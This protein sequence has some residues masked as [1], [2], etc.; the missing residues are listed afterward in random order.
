MKD[1]MAMKLKESGF[2]PEE[3][4]NILQNLAK[5]K[6]MW[7]SK[8][9]NTPGKDMGEF[10]KNH[11]IPSLS[12]E[13]EGSLRPVDSRGMQDDTANTNRSVLDRYTSYSNV[14]DTNA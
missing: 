13:E 6:A 8:D 5:G 9:I 2:S 14:G 11:F 3:S 10:L 7:Q 4:T 1:F 12:P